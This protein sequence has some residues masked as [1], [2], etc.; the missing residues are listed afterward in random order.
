MKKIFIILIIILGVIFALELRASTSDSY[1]IWVDTFS[2]GGGKDSSLSGDY[3]M[4]SALGE[5]FAGFLSSDDYSVA[6]GITHQNEPEILTFNI[7]YQSI[8][9]GILSNL[10][11]A[12]ATHSMSAY[13]NYEGGYKIT[14][15]NDPP[16]QEDGYTMLAI[17]GIAQ[18][19]QVGTEQFGLNLVANSTS[20]ANPLGGSGQAAD[21]YNTP[22]YFAFDKGDII[23]L[24]T[25]NSP[26]TIY[27]VT[28][29]LNFA[30]ATKAGHY[31][32]IM[33]YSLMP[34]F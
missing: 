18:A 28:I 33:N 5:S 13:T 4:S 11:T 29:A 3:T 9:L 30:T 16:V 25:T 12:Y 27:T 14:V 17:G 24:S 32:V 31:H 6:A 21:N 19:S 2:A 8:E 15:I 23:A 1:D 22:N 7:D 20:G 34:N 26:E 10:A